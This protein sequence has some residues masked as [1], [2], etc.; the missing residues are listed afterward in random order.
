MNYEKVFVG[1][2]FQYARAVERAFRVASKH[3]AR[4]PSGNLTIDHA[5][6]GEVSSNERMY[7]HLAISVLKLLSLETSEPGKERLLQLFPDSFAAEI[8]L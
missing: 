8:V 7:E 2:P 6:H 5:A 3:M 1:L 4:I